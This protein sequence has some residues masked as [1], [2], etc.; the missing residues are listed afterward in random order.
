[1]A[2]AVG[3]WLVQLGVTAV[4]YV[5][6][7]FSLFATVSCGD[8]SCDFPAYATITRVFFDGAVVL[9]VASLVCILLL[10]RDP[11]AVIW[12]PVFATGLVI[13][14]VCVTYPLSRA[15]LDLP[16]FDGRGAL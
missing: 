15:A 14:L 1:M 4:V 13:L 9:V 12:P 10:R 5:F 11:D 3:L 2:A 6:M 7:F 16:L 8:A